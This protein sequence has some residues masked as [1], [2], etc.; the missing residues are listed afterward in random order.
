MVSSA[1]AIASTTVAGSKSVGGSTSSGGSSRVGGTTAAAGST[2]SGGLGGSAGTTASAGSSGSASTAASF[3]WGST[4]YNSSG[5]SG[6]AFQTHYTGQACMATCHKHTMTYGGTAYQSNGTAGAANAQIG[7]LIN[8][9]LSTT[10]SGSRGTFYGNLS[11]TVNWA[12][13]QI[14]I[15]TATGTLN[16]PVNASASGNCNSCHSGTGTKR[17]TTP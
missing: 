8:G 1:A 7:L 11:G 17:I 10:Y 3:D 14:A 13:A 12:T 4:A 6:I 15:R 5:G 16:M 9:T 2:G